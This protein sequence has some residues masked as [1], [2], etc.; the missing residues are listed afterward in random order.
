MTGKASSPSQ[1]FAFSNAAAA[2]LGS[3]SSLEQTPLQ[4]GLG[5]A[6][7]AAASAGSAMGHLFGFSAPDL[8]KSK[9]AF[10]SGAFG[11]LGPG[12]SFAAGSQS[13][14]LP[15]G[16]RS[17]TRAV[18]AEAA[19][20]EEGRRS[21]HELQAAPA[22]EEGEEEEE[23]KEEAEDQ[24]ERGEA[25]S[26]E[27]EG[28]AGES[29]AESPAG[30]EQSDQDLNA[31]LHDQEKEAGEEEDEEDQDECHFALP[32]DLLSDDGKV[33]EKAAVAEAAAHE[34]DAAS[35]ISQGKHWDIAKGAESHDV[36][37]A[38]SQ[39]ESEADVDQDNEM[40]ADSEQDSKKDDGLAVEGSEAVHDGKAVALQLD[41][42][43][44]SYA[45]QDAT[46]QMK[47]LGTPH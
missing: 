41:E 16:L 27:E 40:R 1:H 38:L 42:G 44:V 30:A 10:S 20:D 37:E 12:F 35:D 18:A 17:Y 45:Q 33:A 43:D 6:A 14:A 13:A 19:A 3:S 23:T 46:G 32:D 11:G 5:K 34:S 9:S 28:V 21:K 15:S 39:A 7:N 2:Q 8:A 22:D 36:E 25:E 4:M 29:Q 31:G 47:V 26:G 24:E